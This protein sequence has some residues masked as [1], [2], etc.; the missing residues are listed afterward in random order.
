MADSEVTATLKGDQG[1]VVVRVEIGDGLAGYW[2]LAMQDSGRPVR[3]WEGR[4]DDLLPDEVRLPAQA[5]QS[6]ASR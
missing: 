6:G 5:L 2:T 1:E 4:S 3:R